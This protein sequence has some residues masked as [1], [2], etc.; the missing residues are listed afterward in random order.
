MRIEMLFVLIKET[1]KKIVSCKKSNVCDCRQ[2]TKLC[3]CNKELWRRVLERNF[4]VM[5]RK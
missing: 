5:P 2:K 4:S 1:A 3:S